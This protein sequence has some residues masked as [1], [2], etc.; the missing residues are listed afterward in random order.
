MANRIAIFG[1]ILATAVP[2]L[3]VG[4]TVTN[5]QARQ[6]QDS[7]RKVEIS[8]TLTD[9]DSET[10]HISVAIS[11][12]G[13]GT[14]SIVP[15]SV[16]TTS[17]TGGIGWVRPGGRR[18]ILWDTKAEHPT[19]VWS[20]CRA[21]V[22]A[23]EASTMV[24]IP[25]G[26]FLMGNSDTGNDAAY[27][28]S[29][30]LPQHSVYLSG[31]WIGKYEVTRGEY[32]RFMNAGG[33]SH[34]AYWS[35]DGWNWRMNNGRTE[36]YFW[37]DDQDW[38]TG[39]FHQTD[40]HPVVGVCYYEAEAF[41]NWAG[42]RLATEAEWEKAARWAGSHPNVYPWGDTWDA[43][44]CNNIFDHSPAG[45]G[46]VKHQTAPV[47]SY[48]S[49]ASPYGCRDMAGNAWEWV[50]DWYKSYPGSTS[51]FDNTGIYRGLR[52]SSWYSEDFSCRCAYRF[53]GCE[54]YNGWYNFGFRLAR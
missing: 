12:N 43:E 26:S 41:C 45:G 37:V 17:V 50:Q 11:T 18:T 1:I 46:F 36:P 23:D 15:G 24:Y 42:G 53:Y 19:A 51:P 10:V 28:Y 34:Q 9:P 31:Y 14:Y 13:G 2:A 21:R 20:S 47:G 7:S 32:R 39:I 40:N 8:Y 6:W 29:N 48:L 3:A 54:P 33:Y 5:V 35:T 49:D 4:P 16:V 25:A 38:G 44:K 30:E 27:Y 52:G 22:T